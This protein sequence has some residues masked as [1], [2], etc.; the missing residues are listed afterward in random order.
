MFGI[1]ISVLDG[2]A[3]LDETAAVSQACE[4]ARRAGPRDQD[5][6]ALDR[7]MDNIL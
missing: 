2:A 3:R 5:V 6:R 1:I 4:L 7:A